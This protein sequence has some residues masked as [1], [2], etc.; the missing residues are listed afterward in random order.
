M[1]LLTRLV[2]PS[3]GEVKLPVHQFMAE[4]AELQR[5]EIVVAKMYVDFNLDAAEQLQLDNFIIEMTG[6]GF[7]RDEFHDVMMMGERGFYTPAEILT[8]LGIS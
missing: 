6:G 7:N 3:E 2:L 1:S 4:L 8:R 5:G